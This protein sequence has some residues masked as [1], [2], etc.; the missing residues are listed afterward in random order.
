MTRL[1]AIGQSVCLSLYDE[2]CHVFKCNRQLAPTVQ[3]PA[4]LRTLYDSSL[5]SANAV[6]IN[7]RCDCVNISLSSDDTECVYGATVQQAACDVWFEQCAG[8]IT[9]S[10]AHSVLHTSSEKPSKSLLLKIT[11]DHSSRFN[12]PSILHGKEGEARALELFGKQLPDLH[13]NGRITKCGLRISADRFLGFDVR[14]PDTNE[15]TTQKFM[16]S[17]LFAAI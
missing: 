7:Q 4:S 9:A 8:R 11:S 15:I 14:R 5:S 2:T 1:A 12:V 13:L 16:K 10:T 3:L 17:R 6:D